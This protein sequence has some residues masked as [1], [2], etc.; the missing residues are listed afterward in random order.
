MSSMY[1]DQIN[2]VME[3]IQEEFD[4]P[5]VCGGAYATMCPEYFLQRNIDFVI[6]TD[7]ESSI[8]ELADAIVGGSDYKK[9][10]SLCYTENGQIIK[11]EI[12]NICE[13]ID[14]YG[15]PIVH[16][17]N[18]CLIDRDTITMG[19]PQLNT[20]SYEMIASRGC[21]FTC[22]YCCCVA[23]K[24]LFSKGKKYVRTRSVQSVI[25][26]LI[27][28]KKECNKLVFIHFYD[29]I[30]PNLPGWVD[31]FVIK[32]KL[33]IDLPFTI[34]GHPKMMDAEVLKKLVRAGLTEVIM[35]I[36]SGSAHIR[37][38]V[39][40][41]YETQEEII[42][43]TKIIKEAG[44]FWASYDFML[45]HPFE[46]I[47]DLKETYKLVKELYQ[48]FELQLHGLNFLPGTDIVPMAIEQGYLTE[49]EMQEIMYAPSEEQFK[50]YWKQENERESQLWYRMIYC[51]QFR[52]LRSVIQ[53]CEQ[54]PLNQQVTIDVAY[55][56]AAKLHRL[57][58]YY[59]KACIVLKRVFT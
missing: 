17:E 50:A 6:R 58:Y 20:L 21:P 14:L 52:I 30:F 9:I 42:N 3:T 15:I 29:E 33:Y 39:F 55:A 8:C 45:Q 40:H 24:R 32:Y 23:L 47:D 44:V 31:E 53:K 25:D 34:W 43:A 2:V 51:L 13:N 36:Q 16:C 26:E 5:I 12:G 10:P 57:R 19:D 59:K 1:L 37:R 41:R 46:T 18:A 11:N 22:S 56:F 48:P 7:G 27:I 38:D 54:N 28:A 35:G 49:Q 4:M